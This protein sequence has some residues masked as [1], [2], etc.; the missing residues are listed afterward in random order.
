[1]KIGCPPLASVA[2]IIATC[3]YLVKIGSRNREVGFAIIMITNLAL[4]SLREVEKLSMY[5][6][7]IKDYKL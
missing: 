4:R 6:I 5:T 3:V 7:T 2:N 1:M